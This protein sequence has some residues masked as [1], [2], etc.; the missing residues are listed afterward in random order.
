MGN[1]FANHTFFIAQYIREL[2]PDAYTNFEVED[3]TLKM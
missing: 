1:A 2:E 3:T